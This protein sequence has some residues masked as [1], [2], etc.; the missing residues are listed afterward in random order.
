MRITEKTRVSD[1]LNHYGD[2]APVMSV[3]GVKPVG[4][5]SL[6]RII[7][8]FINVRTAAWV[9]KEDLE[10]FIKKLNQAIQK[11]AHS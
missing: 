1:I 5:Y 6:R 10:D 2:I 7:T 3:L 8:R 4:K 9:H 11:T